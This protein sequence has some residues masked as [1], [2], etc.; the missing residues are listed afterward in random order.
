MKNIRLL[1]LIMAITFVIAGLW[2]KTP[3][4]SETVHYIFDP[5]L[6]YLLDLNLKW[7]FAFIVFIIM[8]L[9]TLV[10]K[11]ATD[12][13]ALKGLKEEQKLFKEEIQKYKDDPSK[14]MELQ[15]K[16]LMHL[17]R[18]FELTMKPILYTA[19]PFVLF[20]RWFDDIFKNLG[21]PDI[22]LSFGWFGTYFMLSILFSMILRKI[23]KV[24]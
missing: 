4:I 24:H 22:I 20:I 13:E 9:T 18:T 8:F 2:D 7:G 1:I 21:N 5:T 6:G 19:I 17:P 11:Y 23:L 15:K 10:Q 12:Q 3:I 16:Q 14:V